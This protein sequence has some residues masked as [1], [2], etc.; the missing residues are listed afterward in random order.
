MNRYAKKVFCGSAVLRM[1]KTVMFKQYSGKKK[2]FHKESIVEIYLLIGCHQ[3]SKSWLFRS[4]W[5]INRTVYP[6]CNSTWY[7]QLILSATVRKLES[8]ETHSTCVSFKNNLKILFIIQQRN[9]CL[10]FIQ[11]IIHFSL[12]SSLFWLYLCSK[13]V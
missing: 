12:E 2:V 6:K 5:P 9:F 13:F 4:H 7:C 10:Q 8:H 3:I 11:R 1:T